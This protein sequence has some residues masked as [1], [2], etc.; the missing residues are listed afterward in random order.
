MSMT[1]TS[2]LRFLYILGDLAYCAPFRSW[3][4][5]NAFLTVAPNMKLGYHKNYV[6]HMHQGVQGCDRLTDNDELNKDV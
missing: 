2:S 4:N 1:I 6:N 3:N 5:N